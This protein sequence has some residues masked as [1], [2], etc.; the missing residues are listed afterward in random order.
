MIMNKL[1]TLI[2]MST[3]LFMIAQTQPLN[4][5]FE[6]WESAEVGE[7]PV[8]WDVANRDLGFF[9]SLETVTKGTTD[10]QDGSFH[11]IMKT[12]DFSGT[13]V[14][15]IIT[16]GVITLNA[17]TQTLDIT[18]G[19]PY[20]DRPTQMKGFY[21]YAPAGNDTAAAAVWLLKGTTPD[22]VGFGIMY[23]TTPV[24][25]WTEFTVDINYY[26]QDVP[27]TLN[28]AFASSLESGTVNS[29]FEVDNVSLITTS[30]INNL[31]INNIEI[32]PNP[33]NS[34]FN[35]KYYSNTES[36]VKVHN[37]V[38]QVVMQ[39]TFHTGNVNEQFDISD[40][41]QGIY[42]VEINKNGKTDIKKLIIK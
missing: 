23:F 41:N 5:S 28:I 10:N 2:M 37:T 17:N 13:A 29:Q 27:D 33:A 34:F 40:L 16:L 15:G 38:G 6:N 26:T 21:K 19:M 35:I 39:K 20:T 25:T 11:P 31:S 42:F 30:G 32:S 36:F 7:K 14:P 9:G 1:F 4:Y 3:S 18:G 8:S 24:D 22:T 12:A